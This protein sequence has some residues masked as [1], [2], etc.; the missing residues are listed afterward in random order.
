MAIDL[1]EP[2]TMARM[3]SEMKPPRTF[4][5]DTFFR[6]HEEYDTEHVDVDIEIGARRLAPFVSPR[7]AGKVVDTVGF[8][9]SVYKNPTI[10]LKKV[11]T[12][13]HLQARVPG[14]SLY[15]NRSPEERQAI[16][17]GKGLADLDQ[18][19]T[20]REEWMC[21]QAL[22][23]GQIHVVGDGVDEVI[24]FGRPAELTIA[25]PAA[26]QRWDADTADIPKQLRDW[27]R[28]CVKASGQSPDT[29][30]LG[31][32]AADA[33][34]ANEKLRKTLD[35]LRLDMG[36]ISP[37]LMGTPGVTYLGQLKGTGI[38]LW[39]YDEWYVDPDSGDE[40][41]MVPEKEVLIGSSR[42]YTALRYA[43][44]PVATG[45]DGSSTLS[46]VRGARIPDSWIE[47]EPPARFIKIS[48]RPLPVPIQIGAFL[49]ATVVA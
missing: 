37:E 21:A 40:L 26:A 10:S 8:K 24:T 7:L 15:E 22:F 30:I 42:A 6:N 46:I 39:V 19:I 35:T 20:R 36:Q 32:K 43:A 12:G 1:Y 33:L 5:R 47:K 34:L 23:T 13:D 25:L 9:T 38:D 18:M 2:R 3:L 17:L 45:S 11:L 49:K 16:L 48:S 29:A 41:P 27:R 28:A 4:I 44:V 31:A 14:E